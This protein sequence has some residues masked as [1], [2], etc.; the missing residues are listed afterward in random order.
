MT[1]RAGTQSLIRDRAQG[2]VSTTEPTRPTGRRGAGAPRAGVGSAR[3]RWRALRARLAVVDQPGTRG[4]G[5]RG[6]GRMDWLEPPCE[7]LFTSVQACGFWPWVVARAMPPTGVPL[8][9]HL[10]TGEVVCADPISWFIANRLKAP[11]AFVLGRMGLGKS[12]LIRHLI[13]FCGV[14]G[15]IPIVM[16][17]TR[18]DYVGVIKAMD[19][20][21]IAL[22]PGQ[23]HLNVLD[24]GPL[25]EHLADLAAQGED[26]LVTQCEATIRSQRQRAVGGLCEIGRGDRLTN[27]EENVLVKAIDILD[28]DEDL[29]A[30]REHPIPVVGDLKRLIAGRD[31][32]LRVVVGDRGDDDRYDERVE[33]L[34][35]ALDT[36]D[37]GGIYGDTF[38]RQTDERIDLGRP[39]VFDVSEIDENDTKRLGAVQFLTWMQATQALTAAKFLARAGVVPDRTYLMVGDEL[40]RALRALPLIVHRVDQLIRMIRKLKAGLILCTHTMNDLNLDGPD[41]PLTKIAWGFVERSDMAYLG[42]L[43]RNEMGNLKTVWDMSDTEQNQVTGWS[44]LGSVDPDTGCPTEPPGQSK[45]LLKLGKS[46]GIPFQGVFADIEFHIPGGDTNAD[47]RQLADQLA[48]REPSGVAA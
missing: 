25:A 42:G 5:G 30:E 47:W 40:Y 48:G 38:G 3:R 7:W 26:R 44:D 32:R 39:V 6:G 14:W 33:D 41:G 46:P 31:S 27:R 24:P 34:I 35:A 8:G 13:G 19:G 37:V 45:F 23:K 17:D 36:I 29:V 15:V 43:S 20:Q 12:S 11:T 2:R 4:W 16:S 1:T 21:V 22:G 28:E 9:R 18:P 10:E